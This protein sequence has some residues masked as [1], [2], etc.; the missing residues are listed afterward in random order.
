MENKLEQA[1]QILEGFSN[2]VKSKV[3]LT[4]DELENLAKKRFAI[5]KECPQ[6]SKKDTCKVCGCYMP[7]KTKSKRSECPEKHW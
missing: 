5:C 4:S 6:L 7:A 2:L 1:K 3:G